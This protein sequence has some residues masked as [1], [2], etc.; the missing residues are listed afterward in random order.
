MIPAKRARH[1]S[2]ATGVAIPKA[3]RRLCAGRVHWLA[4][5]DL[6]DIVGLQH[7]AIQTGQDAGYNGRRCTKAHN[8]R[9][10]QRFPL[11]RSHI[12]NGDG[13]LRAARQTNRWFENIN[14]GIQPF[15]CPVDCWFNGQRLWQRRLVIQ[16]GQ[17]H[18]RA[19]K[20]NHDLTIG[21]DRFCA[22]T[23]L[24]GGDGQ[25]C[26]GHQGHGDR[27]AQRDSSGGQGV[28]VNGEVVAFAGGGCCARCENEIGPIDGNFT[29]Q[30][31]LND[32]AGVALGSQW[33]V[34]GQRNRAAIPRRVGGGG[35]AE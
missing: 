34:K 19:V 24:G 21:I 15:A 28:G 4:K 3:K 13:I 26:G 30:R 5:G 2:R 31:R 16:A 20:D 35:G 8:Y 27:V 14:A 9:F 23:R 25:R 12:A 18:H 6:E 7:P 1:L 17:F 29:R 32:E 11:H 22:V 33:L 10:S